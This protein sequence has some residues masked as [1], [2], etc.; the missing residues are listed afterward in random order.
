M[1]SRLRREPRARQGLEVRRPFAD[2]W[3]S[4]IKN[5]DPKTRVLVVLIQ[6]QEMNQAMMITSPLL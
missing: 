5:P 3:A 1:L 6:I 4:K 2:S